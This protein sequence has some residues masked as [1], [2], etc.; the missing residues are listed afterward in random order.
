MHTFYLSLCRFLVYCTLL[1][2]PHLFSM[3]EILKKPLVIIVMGPP[4]S[5]K[6]T[7]AVRLAE[8]FSIPHISTGDMF[9]EHLKNNTA[10]GQEARGYLE[11]G[12]LVPDALVINMLKNRIAQ[13]DCAG[14]FLLDGFPRTVPQAQELDKLIKPTYKLVVVDLLVSDETVKKRISGRRTCIGCGKSYHVLFTPA[15][16]DNQCDTCQAQ[17]TQ[18]KDD[19]EDVVQAR[20]NSYHAQTKPLER[21]YAEEGVYYG[22]D[23][24]KSPEEV[25]GLCVAAIEKVR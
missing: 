2:T 19:A 25:F 1:Y 11:A 15:K 7:Q 13:S 12:K 18:R 22:V 24:E 10:L 4:G 23:G 14:G 5:G 6:G 17:L 21:F 9:R 20:L 16:V 8:R 3:N